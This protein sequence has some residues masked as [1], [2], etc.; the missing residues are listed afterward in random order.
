M[1]L[2]QT[3]TLS[4]WVE[5]DKYWG[6]SSE[7]KLL[8]NEE[9]WFFNFSHISK[10]W[11]ST[12]F[13]QYWVSKGVSRQLSWPLREEKRINLKELEPK[14]IEMETSSWFIFLS[15]YLRLI[16]CKNS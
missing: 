14:S 15:M 8:K 16:K 1:F 9:S 5:M 12:L 3:T 6:K 7:L 11:C 13:P 2:S 4:L 10:A